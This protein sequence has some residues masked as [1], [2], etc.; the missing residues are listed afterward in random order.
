MSRGKSVS[1]KK[2]SNDANKVLANPRSTS[3]QKK[4][5]ESALA[6]KKKK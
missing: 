1:G 5:A 4:A 3:A 6:K 2:A